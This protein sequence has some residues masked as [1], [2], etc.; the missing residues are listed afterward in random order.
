MPDF[1]A[2]ALLQ[3]CRIVYGEAFP[4]FYRSNVFYFEMGAEQP[5]PGTFRRDALVLMT[6]ISLGFSLD[7]SPDFREHSPE[8][9]YDKEI[10]RAVAAHV[11]ALIEQCPCL[12]IITYCHLSWDQFWLP[13]GDTLLAKERRKSVDRSRSL[14]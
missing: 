4:I 10:D 13:L 3:T 12:R 2:A 11:H 5:F 8:S 14:P 7:W 1:K 9:Q 6:S